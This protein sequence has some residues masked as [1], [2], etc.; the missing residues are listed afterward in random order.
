MRRVLV[1]AYYFPPIA[2]SGSLRPLG[3]C[4]YLVQYGWL[5]YVLTTAPELSDPSMETDASLSARLPTTVQVHQV[6]DINPLET[7]IRL[8]GRM[9]KKWCRAIKD[10]ETRLSIGDEARSGRI[11]TDLQRQWAAIKNLVLDSLFAFPDPQCFWLRPAVRKLMHI[12]QDERPDVVF[13]TG[14]P[15]TSLLVGRRLAQEFGVPFIAD[16]RDP[17]T[18]NPYRKPLSSVLSHKS[19]DLERSVCETAARVIANTA[20]LRAQFVADYPDLQEKFLTITNGFDNDAE[21]LCKESHYERETLRPPSFVGHTLQIGHFGSIYVNRTPFLLLRAIQEL[22]KDNKIADSQL[23]VRFVG[24]WGPGVDQCEPVAQELEDRGVLQREP[25]IP[26]EV[27][28]R[29][30]AATPV[31]LILQPS[32]SLQVPAKIFEYIAT[33]RPLLV[34]GGEGATANLVE[35]YQLGLCCKNQLTAI[36]EML[37]GL[38][39]NRIVIKL[40]PLA[41]RTRFN[42]RVLAGDL[43]E[44]LEA[45]YLERQSGPLAL[46]GV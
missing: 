25:P 21:K 44:V 29:Q 40:P 14:G 39:E 22:L 16:F 19:K 30:I 11:Q 2:A 10:V 46:P 27:C 43:A 23:R 3:F 5:P 4:R 34:I 37:Q 41:A 35:R 31:L 9:R 6:P 28:L 20:E 15:W 8:R 12:P 13:A 7:L 32:S 42:Y 33:G 36:K 24:T 45:A 17:W 26:H 18:R 38:I 1:V